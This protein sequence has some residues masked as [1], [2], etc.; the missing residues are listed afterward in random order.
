LKFEN[1]SFAI[2]KIKNI[3]VAI[4]VMEKCDNAA[5]KIQKNKTMPLVVNEASKRKVS[6]KGSVNPRE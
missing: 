3:S 5:R 2:T 1:P 4:V 6:V